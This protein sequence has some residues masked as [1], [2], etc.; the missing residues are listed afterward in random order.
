M[1]SHHNVVKRWAVIA[2]FRKGTMRKE[3]KGSSVYTE[4]GLDARLV[5]G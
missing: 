5:H 4:G 2:M 1:E 3:L